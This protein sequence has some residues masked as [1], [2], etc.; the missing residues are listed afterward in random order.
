MPN[1]EPGSDVKPALAETDER[2]MN[3][4]LSNTVASRPGAVLRAAGVGG[5]VAT[6]DTL[7]LFGKQNA[8]LKLE[9][10][11]RLDNDRVLVSGFN[12]RKVL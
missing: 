12:N 6:R 11:A 2:K 10:S 3:L 1:Q 8:S 7:S 5:R 9:T 4:S